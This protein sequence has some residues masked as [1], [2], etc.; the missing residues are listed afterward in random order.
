MPTADLAMLTPA[1][2]LSAAASRPIVAL[3]RYSGAAPHFAL[4]HEVTPDLFDAHQN[5]I[6]TDGLAIAMHYLT[7]AAAALSDTDRHSQLRPTDLRVLAQLAK[8]SEQWHDLVKLGA[9]IS[10]DFRDYADYTLANQQALSEDLTR[11]NEQGLAKDDPR[12]DSIRR[13]LL[14]TERARLAPP[15]EPEHA[16]RWLRFVKGHIFTILRTHLEQASE[17]LLRGHQR[18][19]SIVDLRALR[20]LLRVNAPPNEKLLT[21]ITQQV[22]TLLATC[23]RS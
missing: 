22:G 1:A 9:P 6:S 13:G 15:T 17:R 21:P 7:A 3:P 11:A 18:L 20:L 23:A 14:A 16:P 12:V 19:L 4:D 10:Q 5:A 8:Y 2:E